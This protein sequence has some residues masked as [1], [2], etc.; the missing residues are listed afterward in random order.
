M[1]SVTQCHQWLP[2]QNHLVSKPNISM[3]GSLFC[4]CLCLLWFKSQTNSFPAYGCPIL[5]SS[6]FLFK[7]QANSIPIYRA[8]TLSLS[9]L[10][11]QFYYQPEEWYTYLSLWH[12]ILLCLHL[13]LCSDPKPTQFLFI[14]AG[15]S[16]PNW[17]WLNQLVS[18][19]C[20]HTRR[21]LQWHKQLN[22][23]CIHKVN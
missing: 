6:P 23:D 13:C 7:S 1:H 18:P 17:K 10:F 11:V 9:L 22:Y 19:F 15:F 8:P 5:S 16:L 2:F 21:T 14:W 20:P 3:R 12:L 4:L